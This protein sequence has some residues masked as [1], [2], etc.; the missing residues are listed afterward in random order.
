MYSA[1]GRSRFGKEEFWV[2]LNQKMRYGEVRD[3]KSPETAAAVN[4]LEKN[5]RSALDKLPPARLTKDQ[6]LERAV[7]GRTAEQ[8]K[9]LKPGDV[10][11]DKGFG[12]YTTS[13][14]VVD[15]FLGTPDSVVVRVVNPKKAKDISAGTVNGWGQQEHMYPGGSNFRVV[16]VVPEAH[17]NDRTGE[18]HTMIYVEEVF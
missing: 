16:K 13:G 15:Q 10:F 8:L 2:A 17:Y 5:L 3:D 6:S 4:F 1:G 7:S 14:D 18:N 12:S 11:K 9:T